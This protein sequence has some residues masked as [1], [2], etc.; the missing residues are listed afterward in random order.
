MDFNNLP[1]TSFDDVK[2]V[3]STVRAQLQD[4]LELQSACAL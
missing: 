2:N 1:E 4:R 3:I